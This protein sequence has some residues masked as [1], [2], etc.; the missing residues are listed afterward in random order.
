MR[1]CGVTDRDRAKGTDVIP[2]GPHQFSPSIN[3]FHHHSH[4][5]I[6]S[7]SIVGWCNVVLLLLPKTVVG[8]TIVVVAIYNTNHNVPLP[9]VLWF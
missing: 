5:I 4:I 9:E 2:K 1:A 6:S 3:I 8:A 7:S